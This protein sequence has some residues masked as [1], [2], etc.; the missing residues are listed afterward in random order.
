[1]G[2]LAVALAPLRTLLLDAFGLDRL[3]EALER[4]HAVHVGVHVHDL[5]GAAHLALIEAL[6]VQAGRRRRRGRRLSSTVR[7]RSALNALNG[8]RV[9]GPSPILHCL[10]V[11]RHLAVDLAV[12]L[13]GGRRVVVLV[14]GHSRAGDCPFWRPHGVGSHS[15]EFAPR[16]IS[17]AAP[18]STPT[19]PRFDPAQSYLRCVGRAH[20]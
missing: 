20:S 18:Y 5:L 12:D 16:V 6:L 15:R 13:A 14:G 9:S 7:S 1:M 19:P 17:A 4:V 10:L 8:W 2:T 3:D 11:G